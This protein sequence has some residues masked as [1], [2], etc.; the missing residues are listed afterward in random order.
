MRSIN[1]ISRVALCCGFTIASFTFA[2]RAMAQS[3]SAPAKLPQASNTSVEAST[4]VRIWVGASFLR[5]ADFNAKLAGED[6]NPFGSSFT[7]AAEADTIPIPVPSINF[8]VKIPFGAEFIN[9]NSKTVHT[10]NGASATV[11]WNLPMFGI[12]V[13]PR[14]SVHEGKLAINIR[15]IG[16]GYYRLGSTL[17]SAAELSISDRHGTLAAK[18]TALGYFG[19]GGVEWPLGTMSLLG[20]VGYRRLLFDDVTLTPTGNFTIGPAGPTAVGVQP[21]NLPETLDYSGWIL[22]VGIGFHLSS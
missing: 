6:N 5:M 11:N 15:P 2:G 13:S 21:T 19:I 3:S 9:A 17:G 7:V 20:E 16:I 4:A 1:K 8:T 10:A 22:R 14:I 18:S 12:Y